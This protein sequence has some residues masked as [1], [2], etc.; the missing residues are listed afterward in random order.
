L[1]GLSNDSRDRRIHAICVHC[2]VVKSRIA[3][4]GEIDQRA[5]IWC[6]RTSSSRASNPFDVRD[7]AIAWFD[8]ADVI[9]N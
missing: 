1:N 8:E 4:D 6:M 7:N 2:P 9:A 3:I 5:Q